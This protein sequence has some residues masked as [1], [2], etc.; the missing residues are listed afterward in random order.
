M[1]SSS[2]APRPSNVG[3]AMPAS[4]NSGCAVGD[5]VV[6]GLAVAVAVAVAVG[7][8]VAFGLAVGLGELVLVMPPKADPGLLLGEAEALALVGVGV[9]GMVGPT[10]KVS[11]PVSVVSAG[12]LSGA[13]V[14]A[15]CWAVRRC[16]YNLAAVKMATPESKI[17]KITTIIVTVLFLNMMRNSYYSLHIK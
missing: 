12:R 4:G 15:A 10:L 8:A 7:L 17:A 16:V 14:G 2:P 13:T 11:S 9:G 6:V 1:R 5:A 3:V